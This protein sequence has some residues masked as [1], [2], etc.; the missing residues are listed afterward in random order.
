MR[1]LKSFI[2]RLYIDPDQPGQF[3]GDLQTLP[4]RRSYPFKNQS[5][6]LDLVHR[7]KGE[8]KQNSAKE[9]WAEPDEPKN[10]R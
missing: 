6:L 9:A 5:E 2:L 4:E 8:V 3:C 7:F 1:I 10:A